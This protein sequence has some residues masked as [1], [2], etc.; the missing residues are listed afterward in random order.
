MHT[1]RYSTWKFR[2]RF[3]YCTKKH[4]FAVINSIKLG[5]KKFERHKRKRRTSNQKLGYP[6]EG[7]TWEQTLGKDMGPETGVPPGKDLGPEA[8]KRPGTRD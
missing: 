1:I 2:K 5:R 4:V 7:R 3:P 6:Q 8:G